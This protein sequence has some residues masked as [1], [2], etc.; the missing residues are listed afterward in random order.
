MVNDKMV[1]GFMKNRVNRAFM[2]KK[3]KHYNIPT[4]EVSSMAAFGNIMITSV[5]KEGLPEPAPR[6]RT[7]VF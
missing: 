5:F 3:K 4:T 7:E 1:N 6:R 2:A